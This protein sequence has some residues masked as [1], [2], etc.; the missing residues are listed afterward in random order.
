YALIGAL[1]VSH[2]R[3]RLIG[4]MFC[5][6]A[7]SFGFSSFAGQY[8]IQSLVVAPGTLPFG[9]A[10]AWFGFWTDMP[11]IAVI[12]LFLPLLFPD[13]RLPSTRWKPV[14]YFAAAS[15]VVA[16]VIT[17]LAPATY[18]DAGYPSIRNP[19]GLDGYAA[20]FDRLGL[21]LQ[22]LLLVL[23]VVSTV[24]LFDRVRRAQ[25][26]GFGSGDRDDTVRPG[27]SVHADQ[28]HPSGARGP[29]YQ[30]DVGADDR[31]CD[32]HRRPFDAFGAARP[33]RAHRRRVLFEEEAG[34]RDLGRLGHFFE[35]SGPRDQ[36]P[37]QVS[38]EE[39]P[40]D[41]RAQ[42]PQRTFER[43]GV[44]H[45]RATV[46]GHELVDVPHRCKWPAHHLVLEHS[47]PVETR[48]PRRQPLPDAEML[49]LPGDLIPEAHQA[50]RDTADRSF[51]GAGCRP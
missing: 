15:V 25:R 1:I 47:W 29:P 50:G 4:W 28:E 44:D 16:V 24:A 46:T 41:D 37:T 7:L 45:R 22:P 39:E 17:M 6:A 43:E 49:G 42:R 18:A 20:L 26:P 34:A 13:G 3:A 32:Q 23:L 33:R 27:H 2:S 19:V 35:R 38:R 14:A 30:A 12:A 48:D 11:G 31:A 8:A 10:M 9:Q 21:L 5:G 40:V 36:E 51:V